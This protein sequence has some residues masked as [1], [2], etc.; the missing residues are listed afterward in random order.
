[1]PLS[2]QFRTHNSPSPIY[3]IRPGFT[4][5]DLDHQYVEPIQ[6]YGVVSW[7]ATQ[8]PPVTG[9]LPT[10]TGKTTSDASGTVAAV[11]ARAVKVAINVTAGSGTVDV[12]I[13]SAVDNYTATVVDFGPLALGSYEFFVGGWASPVDDP[14]GNDTYIA[15]RYGPVKAGS[16]PAT[17]NPTGDEETTNPDPSA[18]NN[19]V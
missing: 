18:D 19:Y 10:V 4:I 11:N 1:M 16:S 17:S 7:P 9:N 2:K 12:L 3:G 5:A 6:V 8:W 14:G 15:T 13:K